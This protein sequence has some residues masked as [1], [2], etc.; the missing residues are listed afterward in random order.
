[1]SMLNFVRKL[2]RKKSAILEKKNRPKS[3]QFCKYLLEKRMVKKKIKKLNYSMLSDVQV[4]LFILMLE[5][6]KYM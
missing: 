4:M 5:L 6:R 2:D 1:M 3:H